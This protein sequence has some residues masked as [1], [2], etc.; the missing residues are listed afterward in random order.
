MLAK[1]LNGPPRE[2]SSPSNNCRSLYSL[3]C[4]EGSHS[5]KL[6]VASLVTNI[7]SYSAQSSV[8]RDPAAFWRDIA[9]PAARICYEELQVVAAALPL[10][11][12][13]NGHNS[14]AFP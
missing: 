12:V 9:A 3:N 10:L 1:E 14:K 8:T 6:L 4:R 7:P 5:R 13:G 2:P 11:H